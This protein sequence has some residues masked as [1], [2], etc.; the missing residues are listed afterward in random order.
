MP[1]RCL[2]PQ[3]LT[4]HR[5]GSFKEFFPMRIF[6]HALLPGGATGI[7]V[8]V[9]LCFVALLLAASSLTHR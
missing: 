3:K 1:C 7:V 5:G 9:L 2:P 8:D 6:R 4:A